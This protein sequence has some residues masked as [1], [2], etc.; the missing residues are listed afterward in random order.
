LKRAT[1]AALII[2]LAGAPLGAQWLNHPTAGI[3]RTADG[4]PNLRALTPRTRT[5]KPDLSG[6][7]SIDGLGY[8]FNIVG[9]H[10]TDMLPW[11]EALYQQRLA[12]YAKDDTDL[13]CLPPGPRAGLFGQNLLKIVQNDG[14]LVV[15]YEVAPTRQIL[16]DGRSLPVN[17][18]PAW[19]GY[20]VGHW[21]KDTLVVESAGF[22]D[23]TWLD[24][25]GHPHTEALHVTERFRRKDFGHMQLEITFD[26]PKAYFKPWTISVNVN[27]VPDTE[28]LEYVCNE[29]EKDRAHLVGQV[30]D[31]KRA[32]TKVAR[33]VLATYVGDYQAG[34]L[35]T[36]HVSVEGDQLMIELPG[37]GGRQPTFAQSEKD[38]V[39]PSLGSLIE[40]V[41]DSQGNITHLLIKIVEG[42]QKAIR[43]K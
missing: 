11:A 16:M 37:G 34:P 2:T 23:R 5:G 9:G 41:K 42:D 4:K 25:S 29:N 33:D 17:P 13:K 1:A 15:L 43:L 12:N 14:L 18:N 22:N 30:A 32:E 27:Y 19:M 39:L 35:G 7:W 20:S 26:D 36:L 28:L 3:P 24:F 31:E 38:F 8:A 10:Q 21:D 40:F 6:I